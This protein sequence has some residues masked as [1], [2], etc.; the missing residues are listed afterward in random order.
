MFFK[1]TFF[2]TTMMATLVIA[3]SLLG[4]C[5]DPVQAPGAGMPD[6]LSADAYPQIVVT[7]KI[8]DYMGF[9]KPV[10]NVEPGKPMSVVVPARLLKEYAINAQYRFIFFNNAG[11][12]LEPQMGF[13]Y[14]R[15]PARV[16]VFMK[17]AAL[18]TNAVDWR[19]EIRSAR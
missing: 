3:A 15:M 10:V 17:G 12:P 13:Q 19:L 6:P 4:G 7:D 1:T 2:K 5:Y 18:D 11:A 14:I 8:S 16:Q 9:H